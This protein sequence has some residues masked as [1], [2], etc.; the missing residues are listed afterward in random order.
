MDSFGET[1]HAAVGF[2]GH[3]FKLAPV[4]GEVMAA[5]ALGQ[6]DPFD[7]SIFTQ[8][9]FAEERPIRSC[10]PY[11]RAKFYGRRTIE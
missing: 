3:G 4:V 7:I 2:S 9:R 11:Q 6:P 5:R 1:L 8:S 10:Y